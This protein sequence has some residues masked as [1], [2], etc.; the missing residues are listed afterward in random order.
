MGRACG[1]RGQNDVFLS[2]SSGDKT[3]VRAVAKRLL[4]DWLKVWFNGWEIKPGDNIPAKTEGGLEH[5]RVLVLCMPVHA[6]GSDWA[7]LE[8]NTF[9][10]HEPLN[11]ERRCIP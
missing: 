1:A 7:Q 4:D 8:A 6:F 5:S 10:F 2:H 3:V 9:R 11:R